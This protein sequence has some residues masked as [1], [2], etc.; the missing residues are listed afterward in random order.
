MTRFQADEVLL[1]EKFFHLRL[2]GG[3]PFVVA[4]LREMQQVWHDLTGERAIRLKECLADVE[5][6]HFLAVGKLGDE[7]VGGLVLLTRSFRGLFATRE[8]AEKQD[9]RLRTLLLLGL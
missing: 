1:A 9:F 5:K 4:G 8:D 3:G 6:L 2:N 7:S